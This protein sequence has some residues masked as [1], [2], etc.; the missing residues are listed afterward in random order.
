LF[1]GTHPIDIGSDYSES[2]LDPNSPAGALSRSS[3]L[4]TNLS[5]IR[6]QLG[7][8][9]N[10][11]PSPTAWKSSSYPLTSGPLSDADAY[12]THTSL[13][14]APYDMFVL[15]SKESI[16]IKGLIG[17]TWTSMEDFMNQG[18]YLAWQANTANGVAEVENYGGSGSISIKVLQ[19]GTYEVEYAAFVH[20]N[21]L[22]DAGARY[23]TD[24]LLMKSSG[25]IPTWY[26]AGGTQ[27]LMQ[28]NGDSTLYVKFFTDLTAGSTYYDKIIPIAY[29]IPELPPVGYPGTIVANTDGTVDSGGIVVPD[30][31][32]SIGIP[33]TWLKITKIA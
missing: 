22:A 33:S 12:H 32:S 2:V 30:G 23:S 5:R 7:K 19:T 17:G 8:A 18:C 25:G 11:S 24:V 6:Y 10:G 28:G 9:I 27:T 20:P 4:I 13:K 29:D 1:Y 3:S 31:S 16:L 15:E 26:F 21:P 14:N